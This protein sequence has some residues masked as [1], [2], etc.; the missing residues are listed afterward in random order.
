MGLFDNIQT[1]IY[2]G[3]DVFWH[4]DFLQTGIPSVDFIL[5]G[6]FG[7]GRLAEIFG[8]WS[9][10]KTMLLYMALANNQRQVSKMGR[11]GISILSESEGAY[12]PEFYRA[13]GG[14]PEQLNLIQ[15]ERVEQ[16]FEIAVKLCKNATKLKDDTPLCLGWDSIAETGTQHLQDE[17]VAGTRDMTKAFLMDQG[18]KLLSNHAKKA[19]IAVIATN[20]TRD[21]IGSMD[22]AT[23]TPGGRGWPFACSQRIELKFDGG[24][25]TSSIYAE[26]TTTKI[27]RWTKVEVVKNKLAVPFGECSLPIY[28]REGYEHPIFNDR[29]TKLGVDIEEALW[30]FFLHKDVNRKRV[31]EKSETSGW[32]KLNPELQL[33]TTES[34]RKANWSR[35]LDTN[36]R[37]RTYL[38]EVLKQG[39][40][41]NGQK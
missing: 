5:G 17:G 24:S 29:K 2:K 38:Y 35:I 32:Y 13:L 34:F 23:H 41:R 1:K 19:R 10:G 15:I 16:F 37:L 18:A 7:Y 28:L 26:D 11:K 22:S 25:K 4:T 39:A 8:G 21:K 3:M 31:L 30:G 12:D 14:D 9:S 6:G 36:P 27:G 33:G 20:Q 40:E